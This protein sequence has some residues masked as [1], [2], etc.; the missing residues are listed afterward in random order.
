MKITHRRKD[1]PY[2]LIGKIFVKMPILPKGIYRFN[3]IPTKLPEEFLTKLEQ[4]IL[5]SVQKKKKKKERKVKVTQSHPPP[6]DPLDFSPPGSSV[7]DIFQAR[8]LK[9]V[10]IPF[11]RGS[12]RP[13]DW[14]WV[15]CIAGR[16]FTICATRKAHIETE[17]TLNSQKNLEIE[18]QSWRYYAPWLQT[19]VQ[20]Y[21]NPSI[22]A[23]N[24]H[25]D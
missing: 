21:S 19:L 3:T 16:F 12:P 22:M 9:W 25:K 7:H 10:A 11:S 23:Q 8:T 5:K 24:R 13:R 2:S 14:T 4:I 6:Y 20:R 18:D 15:S 1:I 17:K